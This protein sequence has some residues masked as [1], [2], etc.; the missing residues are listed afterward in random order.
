MNDVYGKLRDN[1]SSQSGHQEY[2]V[3]KV[4]KLSLNENWNTL[5]K[6]ITPVKMT[7]IVIY[8]KAQALAQKNEFSIL[9]PLLHCYCRFVFILLDFE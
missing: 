4:R 7:K 3:K 5:E 1:I 2:I 6:E 8:I 9:H